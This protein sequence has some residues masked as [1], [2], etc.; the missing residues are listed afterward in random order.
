MTTPIYLTVSIEPLKCHCYDCMKNNN[1]VL[2][3]GALDCVFAEWLLLSWDWL[4]LLFPTGCQLMVGCLLTSK[5]CRDSHTISGC[6][7]RI[8]RYKYI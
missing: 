8:S 3:A 2:C 6:S 7:H 1:K 5:H 4:N